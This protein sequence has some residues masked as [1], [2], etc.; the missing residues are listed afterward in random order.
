MSAEVDR[1]TKNEVVKKMTIL[2]PTRDVKAR[3]LAATTPNMPDEETRLVMAFIDLLDKCLALSPEKRMTPH[4][5]LVHP[6][7]TGKV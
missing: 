2:K 7:I 5:A 3:I 6:F 4:E 1:I